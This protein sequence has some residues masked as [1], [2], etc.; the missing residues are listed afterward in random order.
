MGPLGRRQAALPAG[1][2]GLVS[3]A[4]AAAPRSA[5]NPTGV[6]AGIQGPWAS[7]APAQPLLSPEL[8][9]PL[10]P[11]PGSWG[12]AGSSV[13]HPCPQPVASLHWGPARLPT[14]PPPEPIW[15]FTKLWGSLPWGAQASPRSCSSPAVCVAPAWLSLGL[16]LQPWTEARVAH[17]PLPSAPWWALAGS[18]R[19]ALAVCCLRVPSSIRGRCWLVGICD[20]C[21]ACVH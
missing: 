11:P 1:A 16:C 15:P 19:H 20:C 12:G 4:T 3:G 8:L 5:R 7:P 18:V 9:G 17:C 14:P 13:L 10:L 2:S 21:L 6:S